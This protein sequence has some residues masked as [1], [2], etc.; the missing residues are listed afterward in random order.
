MPHDDEACSDLF[1][2]PSDLLTGGSHAQ[3]RRRREAHGLEPLHAFREDCLI[4]CDLLVHRDRD[5]ALQGR[6]EG[7]FYNS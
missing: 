5:T 7:R 6:A 3:T 4:S 1:G 2:D